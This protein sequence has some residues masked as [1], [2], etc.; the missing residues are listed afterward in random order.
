MFTGYLIFLIQHGCLLSKI[1]AR[2]SQN[3]H[4]IHYNKWSNT[5]YYCFVIYCPLLGVLTRILL[6]NGML[7][8]S[9]SRVVQIVSNQY[10]S[11]NLCSVRS[12]T[13]YIIYTEFLASDW[14]IGPYCVIKRFNTQTTTVWGIWIINIDASFSRRKLHPK[15]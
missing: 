3:A 5:N 1:V 12:F 7:I 4:A 6:S 14:R 9:Y 2:L 11:S 15:T 10:N 13:L 8:A